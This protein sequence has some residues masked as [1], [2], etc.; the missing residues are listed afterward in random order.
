MPNLED[1]NNLRKI[2]TL[3]FVSHEFL[4]EL[5]LRASQAGLVHPNEMMLAG[6]AWSE[7]GQAQTVQLSTPP[8]EPP[9]TAEGTEEGSPE[10][11]HG[12]TP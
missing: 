1:A 2:V 6:R 9:V 11:S 7:L 3:H 8:V 5:F 10:S 12:D 4:T